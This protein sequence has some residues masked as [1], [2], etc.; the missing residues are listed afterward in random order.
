MTKPTRTPLQLSQWLLIYLTVTMAELQLL[1]FHQMVTNHI[2]CSTSKGKGE[3][4]PSWRTHSMPGAG[5]GRG[6]LGWSQHCQQPGWEIMLAPGRSASLCAWPGSSSDVLSSP[7]PSCRFPC[8]HEQQPLLHPALG[9]IISLSLSLAPSI[10]DA[11]W[12]KCCCFFLLTLSFFFS[13]LFPL[14]LWGMKSR[15]SLF[16]ICMD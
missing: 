11:R 3:L 9:L 4:L 6:M 8:A 7:F 15:F 12:F 10:N 5:L 1:C 2:L 14:F 13:P 16:Y